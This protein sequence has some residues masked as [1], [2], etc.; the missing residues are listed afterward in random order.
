MISLVMDHIFRN[1]EALRS[2]IEASG[3]TLYDITA[4]PARIEP[5]SW[6]ELEMRDPARIYGVSH[7]YLILPVTEDETRLRDAQMNWIKQG[8]FSALWIPEQ[9]R[10]RSIIAS[11]AYTSGNISY[12]LINEIYFTEDKVIAYSQP[13]ITAP[14]SS[15][16]R[17][18][19]EIAVETFAKHFAVIQFAKT[20]IWLK[21]QQKIIFN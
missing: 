20:G 16:V 13:N 3:V 7:K 2:V 5:L 10:D 21:P 4:S 9:I 17:I 8:N 14:Y 19:N 15:V 11:D 1:S 12:Y 6:D 18:P